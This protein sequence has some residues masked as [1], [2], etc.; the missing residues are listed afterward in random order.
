MTIAMQQKSILMLASSDLR[1]FA[2]S[3]KQT[4]NTPDSPLTHGVETADIL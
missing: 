1:H 2:Y 3:S 4:S